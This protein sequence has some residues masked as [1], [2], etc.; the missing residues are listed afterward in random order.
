M[1][2]EDPFRTPIAPESDPREASESETITSPRAAAASLLASAHETLE[3]VF[4]HDEFLPGQRR[5]IE[6]LLAGRSAL[7]IFPTGAGKSLCYQ[8]P[9]LLLDGLTLVVSP[10]T[11]LMKDQTDALVRRG[12]EAARLDSSL[13]ADESRAVYARIRA[14]TLRIL[15]VT[16]ERFLNERFRETILRLRVAL[17]AVD[18]AHCISEWGHNFRP[19]YLK[20]A[21]FARQC[22]AERILGLTA[23]ATPDVE[24]DICRGLGVP[25]D[26]VVRTGFYRPNLTLLTTPVDPED[27]DEFLLA[28]LRERDPGPTLVYVT[29]QR[30]AEE[31]AEL[32]AAEELPARPYH[33]GLDDDERVRV[34]DW[35][36][37]S[38]RA[39]VVATIAFGM[40]IDKRD[41]RYVYHYNL[42]KSLE[43]WS[44]EIGRAGRDGAGAIC[45]LLATTADLPILEAFA[46]GDTPAPEA[47]RTLLDDVFSGDKEIVVSHYS[48]ARDHDIRI[49]V[50]RTLLTYLELDGWIT[51]GTPYYSEYKFQPKASS[52]EILARFD[53]ER[54][55]FLATIFK[56]SKPGKTWFR[57]DTEAAARELGCP[58]DRVVRA[59]D[60]LAGLGLLELEAEGV[61]HRYRVERM[62]EDLDGLAAS[63]F[64]RMKAREARDLGRLEQVV[65]LVVVDACQVRALGRHFGE[66]SSEPCGHCSWCLDGREPVRLHA[67]PDPVLDDATW[68]RIAS[69]RRAHPDSLGAA[70]ALARFLSGVTS[71]RL[72]SAKLGRHALFGALAEVP[73]PRLVEWIEEK[74]RA[75]DET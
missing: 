42:P 46:Y 55:R 21:A 10:L 25:A 65:D 13:S 24:V 47:V 18:E 72:V 22:G 33:A 3:A 66:S 36:M 16:P 69:V 60:F 6:Q 4:G 2:H 26:A 62:P 19:D 53:P 67:V 11:A 30:T 12:V 34:Q 32:I 20:L 45:E 9:A 23:T 7:A 37:A 41:I 15:Y 44:Q 38:D 63:L 39:I 51:G 49:L 64:D 52:K 1:T 70:L 40:G 54:Q 29:L 17:F 71:P 5:V 58:R 31:V 27:R 74:I 61:R 68:S 75:G 56:L 48:L 8:L 35:F 57:I 59:L 14:G 73:F 50:V 43:N 28:R